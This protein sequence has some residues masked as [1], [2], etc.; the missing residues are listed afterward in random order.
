VSPAP[1]SARLDDYVDA[2]AIGAHLGVTGEYVRRLAREKRIP[3]IKVGKFVRFDPGE[4]KS[5]L[6]AN[7]RDVAS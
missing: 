5:W 6:D 1:K 7:H 4:V 2:E 3:S